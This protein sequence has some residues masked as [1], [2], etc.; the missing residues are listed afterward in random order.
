MVIGQIKNPDILKQ[1]FSDYSD[2]FDI[3]LITGMASSQHID[4]LRG[5]LNDCLIIEEDPIQNELQEFFM[6]LGRGSKFRGTS[7]ISEGAKILQWQKLHYG[8]DKL[9]SKSRHSK[10]SKIRPDLTGVCVET[11]IDDDTP[12]SL[13]MNTDYC[14]SG[15]QKDFLL[16]AKFYKNWTD[17]FAN[18]LYLQTNYS[19]FS[20]HDFSAA[21]FAALKFPKVVISEVFGSCDI[22]QTTANLDR[23]FAFLA[24]HH[25]ELSLIEDY[26][27]E[28]FS[29]RENWQHILFPSEPAF[30]HHVIN[31]NLTVKKPFKDS[32]IIRG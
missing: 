27:E 10:I 32:Q 31:Q 11:L 25:G 24:K 1:Q 6:K 22:E 13:R 8:L 15:V 26:K 19:N 9:I 21:M 16:A 20:F 23:L 14:F 5:M 28:A 7:G 18:S 4:P 2:G 12:G 3:F 30:L 17:Y 29:F